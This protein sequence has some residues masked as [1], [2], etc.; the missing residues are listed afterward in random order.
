MTDS[1]KDDLRLEYGRSPDGFYY[2]NSAKV[3]RKTM[4]TGFLDAICAHP[5]PRQVEIYN[6]VTQRSTYLTP[7]TVTRIRNGALHL[8]NVLLVSQS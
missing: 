4:V 5:G 6:A 1:S 7:T 8:G 2:W 3:D